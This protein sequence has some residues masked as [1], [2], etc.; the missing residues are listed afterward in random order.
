MRRLAYSVVLILAAAAGCGA[1]LS[2]SEHARSRLVSFPSTFVAGSGEGIT[3]FSSRTGSVVRRLTHNARDSDPMLTQGDRWVYFL[4]VP[5]VLGCSMQLWRV[6][7]SGG[8]AKEL[9]SGGVPGGP[10]AISRNGELLAYTVGPPGPCN[11]RRGET[12]LMLVDRRTGAHRRIDG[13]VEG[14]AWAPHGR[15]LAVVTP[16]GPG[17]VYRIRLLHD[18]FH[19][20]SLTATPPLPCPAA[21][22]CYDMSPSFDTGGGLFYVAQISTH[23][24]DYCSV[25]VCHRWTYA[26][27]AFHGR[28]SRVLTSRKMYGDAQITSATV[29][30]SGCAVVYTL[31]AVSGRKVWRWSAGRAAPIPAPGGSGTQPAWR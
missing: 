31:P 24:G 16:V 17:A 25:G 30:A 26:I 15:G 29:S 19:V 2:A 10:V 1:T 11:P 23:P 14:L 22:G 21:D 9:G 3:V 7:V 28:T 18:P 6:P 12:A 13:Q 27:E 5:A 20:T 4:R 8:P